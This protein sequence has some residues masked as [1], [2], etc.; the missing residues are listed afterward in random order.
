[1]NILYLAN[2]SPL[3]Q[4]FMRGWRN[5]FLAL[6][7][8]F[9]V[10]APEGEE[11]AAAIR[12]NVYDLILTASGEGA[13]RLPVEELNAKGTALVVNGL[14]FNDWGLS[15]EIQAPC[16][17]A[18]EVRHIARFQRKLAWSQWSP[19]LVESFYSGYT[20]L[21]IPV[22]ALP[23]AGDITVAPE[24]VR[25]M[26]DV[27]ESLIF[28][29]NLKHRRRGNLSL[30]KRLMTLAPRQSIRLHGG[31]DWQRFLGI[32]AEP[33]PP[34][35]NT[36]KLYRQALIAPNIHTLRQRSHRIQV[37]DRSFHIPACGGFQICDN[38]MIRDYF[39]ASEVVLAES[40]NEFVEMTT[41][42]LR[43]PDATLPFL[44]KASH[45]IRQ[46]HSYFNRIAALYKALDIHKEVRIGAQSWQPFT[47]PS[48]RVVQKIG[49]ERWVRYALET[50]FMRAARAVKQ[51]L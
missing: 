29:G 6:D 49:F 10:L 27:K 39:D 23:Y 12:D 21:G 43:N 31:K 16:A 15:C 9:T 5:A 32:E 14:P 45:K 20:S 24:T 4:H 36:G 22:L 35:M 1:M 34:G 28:I 48:S 19:E 41:H 18:D 11:F 2:T 33:T 26:A 51:W 30:L 8:S 47:Y 37:N 42:F 7:D 40:E 46:E 25:D 38:P 13:R 44:H 3:A 50:R 17:D